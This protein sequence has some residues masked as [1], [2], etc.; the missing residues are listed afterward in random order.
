MI[1]HSGI[2]CLCPNSYVYILSNGCPV[3]LSAKLN[4]KNKPNFYG[5][6]VLVVVLINVWKTEQYL[7]TLQLNKKFTITVN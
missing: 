5:R 1:F 6:I 7:T 4:K 3:N 2:N